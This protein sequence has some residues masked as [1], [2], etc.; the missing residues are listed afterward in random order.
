[1]WLQEEPLETPVFRGYINKEDDFW[2]LNTPIADTSYHYT[3]LTFSGDTI[4]GW[5]ST[6]HQMLQVDSMVSQGLFD[7][8]VIS[9]SAD[10]YFLQHD[11]QTLNAIFPR[12]AAQTNQ[13][14]I[15][16][17]RG[18]NFDAQQIEQTEAKLTAEVK[19]LEESQEIYIHMSEKGTYFIE[20]LQDGNQI[21]KSQMINLQ[22]VKMPTFTLKIGTYDIWITDEQGTLIAKNTI[23]LS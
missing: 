21:R 12:I 13:T 8:M 9:K 1:M 22:E 16:L 11:R 7:A 17:E 15:I 2:I 20:L 4:Q 6:N 10:N 18:K 23:T 19:L 3:A 5:M 14:H